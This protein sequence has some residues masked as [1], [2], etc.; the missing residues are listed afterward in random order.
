MYIYVYIDMHVAALVGG[1]L[2]LPLL[3]TRRLLIPPNLHT[4]PNHVRKRT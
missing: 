4:S 2:Q 1:D 3:S